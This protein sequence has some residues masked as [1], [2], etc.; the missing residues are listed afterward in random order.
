MDRREFLKSTGAGA[1][2]AATTVATG[3]VAA[4]TALTA[5]AVSQ[6]L[7]ELRL[8]I[9]YEDGFAGP[10]DWAHRIARN[11][12][13]LSGGR[14]RIVT[15]FGVPDAAAAVRAGDADLA[16]SSANALLDL[17]R[18]F[19]Y[20]AGL[21]GDHGLPPA[22]LQAWIT[23][24][25]GDAL[26]DDLAADA[27]LKPLL[28][29]HTGSRAI[30]LATDRVESMQVL[31]GRKI[32]VDGLARD[33][34]RGLGLDVS[35]LHAGQVASAMRAGDVQIAECGGAIVSYALG[36]P[37]VA[38]YSTGA[39]FNQNGTAMV[40]GVRRGLWNKLGTAERA[41][42]TSAANSEYQLSLAEEEAHRRMLYPAPQPASVW[43]IAADL[44]HAIRSVAG[45]VVAHAA[46]VDAKARRIADSY[47]A[48]RRI[49][50][51]DAA[52]A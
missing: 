52:Y 37:A 32:F 17:H 8:A 25:G 23:V 41:M 2:A 38:P 12:G 30:T 13:E 26:W 49:A 46:A 50:G 9:G 24:G 18:G 10:A 4:E 20:F 3:A 28:A 7:Q 39:S 29:A 22:L 19:A 6:G 31:A 5:P 15:T 47:A 45:A 27:G 1:A 48:Y 40:L 43:P 14:F 21:P 36:L 16:F 11:I 33:V 34:A 51:G 42:L 35:S 44:D